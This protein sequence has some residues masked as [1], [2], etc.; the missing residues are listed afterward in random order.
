MP[1]KELESNLL[2]CQDVPK[3]RNFNLKEEGKSSRR[4]ILRSFVVA[5]LVSWMLPA[6]LL[7][8]VV[9]TEKNLEKE[10]KKIKGALPRRGRQ[11]H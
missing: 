4:P 8:T 3:E 2:K 6:K 5:S 9:R 11:G 10:E 1:I 7:T